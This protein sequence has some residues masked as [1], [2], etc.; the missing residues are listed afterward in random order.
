[1]AQPL[2]TMHPSTLGSDARDNVTSAGASSSVVVR[3][4]T[5][6]IVAVACSAD[7]AR[8]T[9]LRVACA[10][11]GDRMFEIVADNFDGLVAA[12]AR[13]LA[14]I[15]GGARPPTSSAANMTRVSRAFAAYTDAVD[16]FLVDEEALPLGRD[17][18]ISF[19][20]YDEE[21]GMD[22]GV[23]TRANLPRVA[24]EF[25][26]AIAV[27]AAALEVGAAHVSHEKSG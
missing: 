18:S 19:P 13:F 8:G 6:R 4:A 22:V 10:V 16:D 2:W 23:V 26:V 7:S 3:G 5:Y 9:H 14:S 17:A 12:A 11:D 20:Q 21:C 27:F 24:L 1:M 25:D 15:A